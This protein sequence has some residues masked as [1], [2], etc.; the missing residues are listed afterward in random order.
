[1]GA[2]RGLTEVPAFTGTTVYINFV[3]PAKAGVLLFL[4]RP[5]P[6][7]TVA[8]KDGRSLISANQPANAGRP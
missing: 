5:H 6:T 7:G 1:M 8:A 3:T 2:A 4:R